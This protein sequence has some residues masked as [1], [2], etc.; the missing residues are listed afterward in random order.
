MPDVIDL[1]AAAGLIRDGDTVLV[2]GSGGGHAVPEAFKPMGGLAEFR[3]R[4]P[5]R[6]RKPRRP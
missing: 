6:A 1:K 3:A 2:G 5:S 4:T